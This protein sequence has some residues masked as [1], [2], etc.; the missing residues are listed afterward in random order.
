M[1]TE[2]D[3]YRAHILA[4]FATPADIVTKPG[5]GVAPQYQALA[6]WVLDVVPDVKI[7]DEALSRLLDSMRMCHGAIRIAAYEA[8]NKNVPAV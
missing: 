6:D 8:A 7:R 2:A 1:S 3:E 4:I 5:L